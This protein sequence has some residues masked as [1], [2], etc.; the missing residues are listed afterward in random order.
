MTTADKNGPEPRPQFTSSPNSAQ[1]RPAVILLL[2]VGVVCIALWHA[3]HALS[4]VS[5]A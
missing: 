1:A 3:A 2:L 5:L 4:Q